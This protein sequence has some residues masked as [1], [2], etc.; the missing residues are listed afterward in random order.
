MSS[1]RPSPLFEPL[2]W[3]EDDWVRDLQDNGK[4]VWVATLTDGRRVYADDGRWP[5][6]PNSAW[7]RLQAYLAAADQ[8][9][10]S[11]VI[12]FRT[13]WLKPVPDHQSAYW[14]SHGVGAFVGELAHHFLAVGYVGENSTRLRVVRVAVPELLVLTEEDRSVDHGR[15]IW[16]NQCLRNGNLAS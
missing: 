16:R 13:E 9:I 14:L 10:S 5:D 12:K 7:S 6:R 1:T 4:A 8:G 11:L 3:S 15:T 2:T